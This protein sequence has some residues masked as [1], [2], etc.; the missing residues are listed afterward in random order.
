MKKLVSI[1]AL[2]AFAFT[3][4]AQG[5]KGSLSFRPEAG[6]SYSNVLA[7]T[8]FIGNNPAP[9]FKIGY[10]AGVEAEYMIGN[11]FSVSGGTLVTREGA[12]ITRGNCDFYL[13]MDYLNIPLLIHY[14]FLKGL[15][16]NVG[17]QPGY[18]FLAKYENSKEK[19]NDMVKKFDIAGVAG[20]SYE[21]NK[22]VFDVRA[23]IGAL[24]FCNKPSLDT[25]FNNLFFTFTIGY[26]IGK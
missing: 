11:A 3:V 8:S 16:L 20:L 19:A 25:S 24:D 9:S 2:L 4:S 5:P 6:L 13:D 17:A 21:I 15:S 14:Y 1:L 22:L 23:Q 12:L 26:R 18:A 10:V 7:S